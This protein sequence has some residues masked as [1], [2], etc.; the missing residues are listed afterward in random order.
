MPDRPCTL[1]SKPLSLQTKVRTEF[2]QKLHEAKERLPR[3]QEAESYHLADLVTHD[4]ATTI[5]VLSGYKKHER[6]DTGV[7]I[8]SLYI[9]KPIPLNL[10]TMES[11]LC[12]AERQT[13]NPKP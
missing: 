11:P 10:E 4:E 9:Y 5:S 12:D 6:H 8:L 3:R 2:L 1:N 13:L 7:R